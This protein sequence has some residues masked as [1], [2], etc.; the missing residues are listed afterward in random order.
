L[1]ATY[2]YLLLLFA[3]EVLVAVK[4]NQPRYV[5]WPQTLTHKHIYMYIYT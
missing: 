3:F 2:L 5:V 1:T 4:L